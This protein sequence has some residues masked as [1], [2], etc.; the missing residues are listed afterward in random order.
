MTS[1]EIPLHGGNVSTVVRVGDTVRRNAGPWTPSV[2]ALLRHLEYVGF[3]GSPRA[4]GMDSRNREVLSYLEGSAGSTRSP[5]T[6]SPTRHWSPSPPC[7]GCSTTR[8]TVS[9]RR[10]TRSGGR[11]GRRP[12]T[13]R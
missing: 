8:N 6:G 1:Q 9:S 12:R 11:S 3:T 10:R 7:C 5:R 2:H 13:P 4:L